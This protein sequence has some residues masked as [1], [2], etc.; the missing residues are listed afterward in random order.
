MH[1]HSMMR[2][3]TTAATC[4]G[5]VAALQAIAV[6]S[7]PLLSDEV[8]REAAALQSGY[9]DELDLPLYRDLEQSF[10]DTCRVIPSASVV[11]FGNIEVRA[12][13]IVPRSDVAIDTGFLASSAPEP[14]RLMLDYALVSC[15]NGCEISIVTDADGRGALYKA[16][17]E[18]TEV[19]RRRPAGGTSA[20]GRVAVRERTASMIVI[21]GKQA[22]AAIQQ[23]NAS[24]SV[25][26]FLTTAVHGAARFQFHTSSNTG[27]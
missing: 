24:R 7:E 21:D 20:G 26:I 22:R 2:S 23:I 6:S 17:H 9:Y 4:V 1:D 14:V 12:K 5:V 11:R 10:G 15:A 19:R 8:L 3:A 16:R 25:H 27:N 13:L 18:A